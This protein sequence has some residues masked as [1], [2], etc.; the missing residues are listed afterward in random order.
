M[1]LTLYRIA[2]P[3]GTVYT[4]NFFQLKVHKRVKRFLRFISV[5]ISLLKLI[6]FI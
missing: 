5:I 3:I 4:K 1:L 2:M 6:F